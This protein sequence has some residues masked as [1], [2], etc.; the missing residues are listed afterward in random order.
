MICNQIDSD[1]IK[2]LG[3]SHIVPLHDICEQDAFKQCCNVT[4]RIYVLEQYFRVSPFSQIFAQ[5]IKDHALA[6]F[7]GKGLIYHEISCLQKFRKRKWQYLE[8]YITA[9]QVRCKFP[10]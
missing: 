10:A 4:S 1:V 8:L 6:F 5:E 9:C 3:V 2:F 7:H